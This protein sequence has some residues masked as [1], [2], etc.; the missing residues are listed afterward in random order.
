MIFFTPWTKH[1]S[2]ADY[3]SPCFPKLKNILKLEWL[4]LWRKVLRILD[5]SKVSRLGTLDFV[6]ASMWRGEK[7]GGLTHTARQTS[8]AFIHMWRACWDVRE[9]WTCDFS[10]WQEIQSCLLRCPP[11]CS[12]RT[13][14]IS[15]LQ[16]HI[17][18]WSRNLVYTLSNQSQW[19]GASNGGR[20]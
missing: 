3:F 19:Y 13:P 18:Q 11:T 15:K 20:R 1:Q 10:E 9:T 2:L 5:F 14:C 6:W 7:E 17:E 4:L 12:P 16:Y 8:A